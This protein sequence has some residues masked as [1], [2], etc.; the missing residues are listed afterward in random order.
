MFYIELLE[1][2]MALGEIATATA[3]AVPAINSALNLIERVSKLV[4]G[5]ANL[6]AQEA[7]L[8]L[9]EALLLVK[10]EN[11]T[12][13][14]LNLEMIEQISILNNSAKLKSELHFE[15]PVYYDKQENGIKKVAFCQ[16]CQDSQNKQ[17]RLQ[18]IGF[19]QWC[20]FVC[21]NKFAT[22]RGKE[23]KR[24]NTKK[25]KDDLRRRIIDINAS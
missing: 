18:T 22:E 16:V 9:R 7:V 10:E 4:K 23:H 15:D 19:E 8:Q 2:R 25:V 6:E 3:A 14:Q 5:S 13:R 1:N 24:A 12:L 20:C 11:L 21:S 17:V